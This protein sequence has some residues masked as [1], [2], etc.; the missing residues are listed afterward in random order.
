[1]ASLPC[2]HE[3]LVSVQVVPLPP[4]VLPLVMIMGPCWIRSC[5][6]LVRCGGIPSKLGRVFRVGEGNG[7]EEGG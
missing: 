2:K 1:M 3:V 4:V 7:E 6:F 5:P